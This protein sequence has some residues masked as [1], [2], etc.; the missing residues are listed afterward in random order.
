ML[1]QKEADGE[2]AIA[3]LGPHR[4]PYPGLL[5]RGLELGVRGVEGEEAGGGHSPALQHAR[6][7]KEAEEDEEDG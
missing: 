6:W 3:L 7:D 1:F 4:L 5:W 2:Q